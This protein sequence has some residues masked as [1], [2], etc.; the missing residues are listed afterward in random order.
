MAV[1]R[2]GGSQLTLVE[3]GELG[4]SKSVVMMTP[5]KALRKWPPIRARGWASGLSMAP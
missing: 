5:V 3:M 2:D 4:S 1:E